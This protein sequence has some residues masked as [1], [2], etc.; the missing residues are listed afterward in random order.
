[1]D[2]WMD[3]D[4]HEWADDCTRIAPPQMVERVLHITDDRMS[5]PPGV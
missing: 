2:G 3:D 4:D 5:T 1:M